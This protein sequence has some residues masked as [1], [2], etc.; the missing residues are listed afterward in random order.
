MINN[1]VSFLSN[2]KTPYEQLLRH[3]LWWKAPVYDR[4]Y[5]SDTQLDFSLMFSGYH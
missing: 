1:D 2:E 3:C 4:D 5:F